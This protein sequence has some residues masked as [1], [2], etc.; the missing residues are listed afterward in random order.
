MCINMGMI[1]MEVEI[2]LNL[3]LWVTTFAQHLRDYYSIEA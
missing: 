3:L 1:Y 2:I